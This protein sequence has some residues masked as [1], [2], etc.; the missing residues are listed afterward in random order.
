VSSE[1]R[2]VYMLRSD[3]DA[4][5]HYVGVTSNVCERLHQHN[6][7]LNTH[8]ARNCPW[9]VIVAIEF[10]TEESAL[11]FERY[12]KSGSGRAFAKRHFP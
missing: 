10:R 3:R 6:A 5:K 1:K 4:T 7:G 12:L 8:T 11:R 2:F 9:R